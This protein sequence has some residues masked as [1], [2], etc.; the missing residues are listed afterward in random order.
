MEEASCQ[1]PR[2]SRRA[3][4]V[5]AVAAIAF[6]SCGGRDAGRLTGE[7]GSAGSAGGVANDAG[8]G[9]CSRLVGLEFLNI[10][11][12]ESQAALCNPLIA[13][14]MIPMLT[15]QLNCLFF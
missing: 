12:F 6:L 10:A 4:F 5:C 9:S 1:T 15:P 3:S 7:G 11:D 8:S 14:P 2:R 13:D